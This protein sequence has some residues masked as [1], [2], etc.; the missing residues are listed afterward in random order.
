MAKPDAS[1]FHQAFETAKELTADASGVGMLARCF[2]YLHDRNVHLEE[3][4]EQIENY[5]NSGMAE[6]EHA[7]LVMALDH[8]RDAQHRQGHEDSDEPLGL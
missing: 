1:D 2:L 4:Y 7:R 6:R 3:V 5:L 8:A